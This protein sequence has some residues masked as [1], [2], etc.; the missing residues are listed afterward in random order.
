M[1]EATYRLRVRRD[2]DATEIRYGND[3]AITY[4]DGVKTER[5]G[6]TARAQWQGGMLTVEHVLAD[7]SHA[8]RAL[9]GSTRVR[10]T[11]SGR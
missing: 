1:F 11:S 10:A 5:D 7:G 3:P 9:L 4:R 8:A 6:A 2:A